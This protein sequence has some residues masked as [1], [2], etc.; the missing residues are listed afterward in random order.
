LR[1]G[2][3]TVAEPDSGWADNEAERIRG[4]GSRIWVF[5]VPLWPGDR[6][7]N[8]DELRAAIERR[9]GQVAFEFHQREADLYLYT[10]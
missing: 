1:W 8:L 9:G 6:Q 10:F 2:R 4:T 3:P 5:F 7:P